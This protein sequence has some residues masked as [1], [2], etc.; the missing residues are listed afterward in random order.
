MFGMSRLGRKPPVSRGSCRPKVQKTLAQNRVF[1][2]NDKHFVKIHKS[3]AE[4]LI[5][6]QNYDIMYTEKCAKNTCLLFE[7]N[8]FAPRVCGNIKSQ[9]GV[10]ILCG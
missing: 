9:Q 1:V 10:E 5:L 4:A 3:A 8:N 2:K 7:Q 6:S